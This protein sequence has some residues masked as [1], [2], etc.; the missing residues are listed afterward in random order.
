MNYP[1]NRLNSDE[2]NEKYNAI[3]DKVKITILLEK[4]YD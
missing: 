3:I 4:Y 2:Y 1:A